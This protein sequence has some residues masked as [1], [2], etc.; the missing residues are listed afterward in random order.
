MKNNKATGFVG[1]PAEMWKM[2]CIVKGGIEI[3]VEMFNKVKKGKGFPDD[4]K[5]AIICPICKGRGKRG[6]PAW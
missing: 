2:L 5:T 4:W 1:I 6:E 3:L